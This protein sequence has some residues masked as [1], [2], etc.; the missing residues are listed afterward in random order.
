MHNRPYAAH[1]QLVAPAR[2]RPELWRLF[3]GIVTIAVVVFGFNTTLLAAIRSMAPHQFANEL[4][5][6]ATP[7]AMIVLLSSFGF[8]IA[9]IALATRLLQKR[10]LF[11][12]LGPAADTA[13]QFWRVFRAL[14]VLGAVLLILPPYDM[15]IPLV[16]NLPPSTWLLL[17][18]VSLSVILIQTAAEEILFRGYL[19][20]SLAARFQSPL[21]WLCLP[22]LLF[23]L[24][25]YAPASAG[26]NALLVALWSGMFGLLAADLTARSGT[27]GP[28]IA[29]H[30]FN[31][32]VA[33]LVV[34]LPDNLSG[35]SL[36]ILPIDLSDTVG[37]REWLIVD[38]AMMIVGWLVARV[39]L[40]R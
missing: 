29:L 8:V 20:Q 40:R 23:A 25:H 19:Q 5:T 16:E 10:S 22:S 33:L 9:G 7:L 13:R 15:G 1:E 28:A 4:M 32:A 34:S 36:F 37:L 3:L 17:L 6:G 11:S 2:P 24:G 30:L 27:L 21:I 35:L 31:N 38:F 18:P 12:I 39:V 14:L 26:D